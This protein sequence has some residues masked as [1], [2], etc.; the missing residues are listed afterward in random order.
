MSLEFFLDLFGELGFE[1]VVSLSPELLAHQV[2]LAGFRTDDAFDVFEN[3][4]LRYA[5]LPFRS[6]VWQKHRVGRPFSACTGR[7]GIRG[8]LHRL[9]YSPPA[10][11]ASSF[12]TFLVSALLRLPA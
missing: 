2:R 6:P 5:S 1:Q 4:V 9:P 3:F 7:T 10:A 8:S 11:A 12:E